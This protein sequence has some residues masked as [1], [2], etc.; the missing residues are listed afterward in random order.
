M[1]NDDY[2]ELKWGTGAHN[3]HNHSR[4]RKA[5]CKTQ[6]Q[7]AGKVKQEVTITETGKHEHMKEIRGR[8]QKKEQ[9]NTLKEL[10]N[11]HNQKWS[12]HI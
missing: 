4:G 2:T 11:V 5:K 7:I 3:Q 12:L 9:N 1:A 6:G 10:S 8:R